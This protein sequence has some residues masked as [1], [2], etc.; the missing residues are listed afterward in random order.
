MG[1]ELLKKIR[2]QNKLFIIGKFIH[3]YQYHRYQARNKSIDFKYY[4][5][6][7]KSQ[8][9]APIKVKIIHAIYKDISIMNI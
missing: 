7:I 2:S 3:K 8:L 5:V 4:I 9:Y 1:T 6:S